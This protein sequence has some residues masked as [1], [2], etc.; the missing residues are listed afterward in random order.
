MNTTYR[1]PTHTLETDDAKEFTKTVLLRMAEDYPALKDYYTWKDW[2]RADIKLF[3]YSGYEENWLFASS[4]KLGDELVAIFRG[5]KNLMWYIRKTVLKH[6]VCGKTYE[7]FEALSS[8]DDCVVQELL[9]Y[10]LLDNGIAPGKASTTHDGM[11]KKALLAQEFKSYC[12]VAGKGQTPGEL[13]DF[14]ESRGA[15]LPRYEM[16]AMTFGDVEYMLHLTICTDGD[17]CLTE[18][19][20]QMCHE[21]EAYTITLSWKERDTAVSE[22]LEVLEWLRANLRFSASKKWLIRDWFERIDSAIAGI[23]SE[24]YAEFSIGGNYEGTRFAFGHVN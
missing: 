8:P 13:L 14:L 22:A 21:D 1:I 6:K 9:G 7:C 19:L 20:P 11:T 16:P 5:S 2:L 17:F 3:E 24:L 4:E 15:M 12:E 23:K 18:V 10:C